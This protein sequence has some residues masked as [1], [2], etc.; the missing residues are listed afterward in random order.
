MLVKICGITSVEDA[1]WALRCGANALGFVFCPGSP[2]YL[3]PPKAQE[4]IRALPGECLRVGVFVGSPEASPAAGI[5]I[6]QLH[7]L[8]S[9]SEIRAFGRKVWVATGPAEIELFPNS[10]LLIDT[11]WGRGIAA[12]WESLRSVP[13]PFILSGGL[14]P[15]NV[16]EAIRLLHPLGVDVSSGVEL[17]SGRKD[18]E[19]IR[20]FLQNVRRA[21]DG[22][23]S[24]RED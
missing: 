9:E 13:R 15:S 23:D 7:G 5:D 14:T 12:D 8:K 22:L 3:T 4:I 17:S 16:C 10:D 21:T 2:R 19:K 20:Q 6:V 11:S 18:P 1:S 24:E